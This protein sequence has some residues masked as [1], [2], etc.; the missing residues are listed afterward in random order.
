MNKYSI[1]LI[2]SGIISL[3]ACNYG[4][5]SPR[6]FSLP[7]GDEVK[8]QQVFIKHQ[9]LACHTLPGVSDEAVKL[10]LDRAVQLGGESTKVTTY[11]DLVTSV[12][13][14]SHKIARSYKLN[15]IDESGKSKM[16]NYNDVMTVTELVDLVTY[17]QPHYK[18]KPYEYTAYGRY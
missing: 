5:D 9:C 16:R 13:N 11:A 7:K 14:P 17:L 3:T 1:L 18:V 6:G 12:I 15:T 2:A 8:G 4:P 10:Q